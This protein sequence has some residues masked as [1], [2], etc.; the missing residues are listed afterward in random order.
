MIILWLFIFYIFREV[1][2]KSCSLLVSDL[3]FDCTGH[4]RMATRMPEDEGNN[5]D[6]A[7][8]ESRVTVSRS[9]TRWETA[10]QDIQK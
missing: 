6:G 10:D 8:T 9:G 5:N 4:S 7:E 1:K 3:T 2:L